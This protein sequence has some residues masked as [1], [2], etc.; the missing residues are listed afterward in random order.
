MTCSWAP[1][2]R[3]YAGVP[4]VPLTWLLEHRRE[5]RLVDV[6]EPAEFDGELGHIEGAELLP[7]GQLRGAL[8]A[9]SR[10]AAIVVVCRSGARSAQGALILEA[11]GFGKVGNLAGGMIAWR[12][13]GLPVAGPT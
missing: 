10:D 2:V 6:R 12:G 8:T 13:A 5:V 3:T 9:W 7:L 11:S 4:E 1:V